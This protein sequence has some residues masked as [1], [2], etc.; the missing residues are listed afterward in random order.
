MLIFRQTQRSGK[1][2]EPKP[3]RENRLGEPV[4]VRDF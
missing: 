3:K 2:V 1:I 4:F